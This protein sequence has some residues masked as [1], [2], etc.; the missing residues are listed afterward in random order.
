MKWLS[1]A[2]FL[3]LLILTALACASDAASTTAD[4][5]KTF[6]SQ[7]VIVLRK[8]DFADILVDFSK[9]VQ[10]I[11][12]ELRVCTQDRMHLEEWLNDYFVKDVSQGGST[13]SPSKC[14]PEGR[15]YTLLQD[16]IDKVWECRREE[17]MRR[18]FERT[19]R[20]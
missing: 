11:E 10:K 6:N 9:Y 8:G 3:P 17:T 7:E 4:L 16:E 15:F 14:K 5:H 13:T 2:R 20:E 18:E 19:F 12:D 1:C